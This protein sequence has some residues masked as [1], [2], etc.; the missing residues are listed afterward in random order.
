MK[1]ELVFRHIKTVLWGVAV[2]FIL[3]IFFTTPATAQTQEMTQEERLETLRET[4][5][6]LTT[7]VAE[8]EAITADERVELLRQLVE[9]SRA[10]TA[11]ERVMALQSLGLRAAPDTE[12]DDLHPED[13][14]LYRVIVDFDP[15]SHQADLTAY[16]LTEDS[17]I[18]RDPLAA[19]YEEETASLTL[20]RSSRDLDFA[21]EVNYAEDQVVNFLMQEYDF[22]DELEVDRI[23]YMSARNPVRDQNVAIPHNSEV[24]SELFTSFGVHSVITDVMVLPN[25]GRGAIVFVSDQQESF[26]LSLEPL[27]TTEYDSS[28]HEG[29]QVATG[30]YAYAI[31]FYADSRISNIKNNGSDDTEEQS[32]PPKVSWSDS[33]EKDEVLEVINDMLTEIP[34]TAT[35]RN[36]DEDF[37]AFMTANGS[38][39]QRNEDMLVNRDP[40]DVCIDE[41]DQIIMNEYI[42]SLLSGLEFNYLPNDELVSYQVP[43]TITNSRQTG[44]KTGGGIFN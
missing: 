31:E 8:S 10:I 25:S 30:D 18:E 36:A 34:L 41:G 23:T 1:S 13:I 44:C 38:S 35:L 28:D 17:D 5:G 32:E 27:F 20:D 40:E 4:L 15:V 42:L 16:F 14:G 37:L 11:L 12:T 39:Y 22:T 6:T 3:Q 7:V 33:D 21:G 9:L 24:A 29:R 19:E 26:M 43:V 2:A